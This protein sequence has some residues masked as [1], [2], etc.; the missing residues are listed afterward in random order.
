MEW[1]EGVDM[2]W[3]EGVDMDRRVASPHAADRV[4]VPPPPGTLTAPPARS[5]PPSPLPAAGRA[6]LPPLRL[7]RTACIDSANSCMDAASSASA[8]FGLPRQLPR[9][10]A[11]RLWPRAI[12]HVQAAGRQSPTCRSRRQQRVLAPLNGCCYWQRLVAHTLARCR[13]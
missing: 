4:V 11:S 3:R 13:G 1:R 6:S 10:G 5:R 2:E 7:P 9:P 12:P 8:Y